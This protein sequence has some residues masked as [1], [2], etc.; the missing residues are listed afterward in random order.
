[1]KARVVPLARGA[2]WLAEGWRLFRV[3]P[4]SW[5]ALVIVYW[6]VMTAV[7]LVPLLGVLVAMGV[8]LLFERLRELTS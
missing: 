8:Y 4:S 7:S 5:L 1:M 3:S 2:R 6:V